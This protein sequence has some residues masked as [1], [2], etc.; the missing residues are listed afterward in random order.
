MGASQTKSSI[1]Q[2]IQNVIRTSVNSNS[3]GVVV[4]SL[5]QNNVLN[6]DVLPGGIFENCS[7]GQF[8]QGSIKILNDVSSNLQA[9]LTN[10][11]DTN[12]QNKLTQEATQGMFALGYASSE[13]ELRSRISNEV[14]TV[15]S[16]ASDATTNSFSVQGNA[17]ILKIAGTYRCSAGGSITQGNILDVSIENVASSIVK[18]GQSNQFITDLVNEIDQTASTKGIE[19]LFGFIGIALIIGV[20]IL[21]VGVIIFLFFK[22][23][24][25]SRSSGNSDIGAS[26]SSAPVSSAPVS[27]PSSTK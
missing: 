3:E 16:S 14:S 4:Q 23:G 2:S 11:I 19:G 1:E 24:G 10:A 25:K 9:E 7:I 27:Q 20:I 15:V 13:S 6:I 12:L 21:A 22:L 17:L 26:V 5:N 8:N 18:F